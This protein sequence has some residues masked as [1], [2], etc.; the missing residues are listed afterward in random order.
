M[1]GW[2]NNFPVIDKFEK[3]IATSIKS[4]D[5]NAP[6]YQKTGKVFN[7]LKG[8]ID[9]LARFN[10]AK[11]KNINIQS[12]NILGKQLDLALP[13][14]SGSAVQWEQ[15]QRA[16]KYALQNNITMTINFIK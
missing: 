6:T 8:Y 11:W 2:G 12:S 14:G 7:T 13:F 9:D 10:G 15:I 4:L 5:L 3:G 16:M 1:S